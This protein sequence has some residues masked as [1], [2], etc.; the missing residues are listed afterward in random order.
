MWVFIEN[1]CIS[2]WSICCGLIENEYISKFLNWCDLI[3]S[4]D[5]ILIKVINL[6]R[7][8]TVCTDKQ[9]KEVTIWCGLFKNERISKSLKFVACCKWWI[10]Y[11]LSQQALTYQQAVY[12][13]PGRGLAWGIGHRRHIDSW[14]RMPGL[15][16]PQWWP[17]G[18]LDGDSTQNPSWSPG[19]SSVTCCHSDQSRLLWLCSEPTN[20]W[21]TWYHQNHKSMS[22][23]QPSH[24]FYLNFN[25]FVLIILIDTYILSQ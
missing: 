19:S 18:R 3:G 6:V 10:W 11:G 5:W 13:M 4:R 20:S 12:R 14:Y 9:I 15:N 7:P 8:H 22:T 17:A 25:K 21:W 23:S 1:E 16:C 2:K 24:I